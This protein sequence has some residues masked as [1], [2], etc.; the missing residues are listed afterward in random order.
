MQSTLHRHLPRID[1][2]RDRPQ[3]RRKIKHSILLAIAGLSL[4]V[5]LP[6][7]V[8]R[9][10]AKPRIGKLPKES[11]ANHRIRT[12]DGQQF[13]LAGLRE[14]VVVLDFFAVW[15]GHSREHIPT[16]NKF[17]PADYERGLQVIGLAVDDAESTPERVRKFI[18]ETKISYPVAMIKDPDFANY[19]ESKDLS[20]PQTLVFGR[21]GRLVAFFNGHDANVASELTATIKR[22]LE[23]R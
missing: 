4:S 15:C 17:G 16:L 13:T 14:N 12:L 19:V 5:L 1:R 18:A 7:S 3:Y 22:E 8:L 6:I 21:D 20:V 10:E 23:K 11:V 2:H 9:S